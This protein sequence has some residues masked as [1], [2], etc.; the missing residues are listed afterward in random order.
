MDKQNDIIQAVYNR[1]NSISKSSLKY[2][3]FYPNDYKNVVINKL[4][5]ALIYA[6]S[7]TTQF[8]S[9][10]RNN[11]RLEITIFLYTDKNHDLKAILD[12]QD[13]VITSVIEDIQYGGL[14]ANIWGY[15]VD[16]GDIT[17]YMKPSDIGFNADKSVRSITFDFEYYT[18]GIS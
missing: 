3:G 14:V 11:N 2:L 5:A 12:I 16:V 1:V 17:D 4:P 9:G 15:N 13:K 6:G 18:E 10:R 7:S 8:R